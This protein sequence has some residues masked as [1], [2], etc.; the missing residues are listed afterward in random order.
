MDALWN[1]YASLVAVIVVIGTVFIFS[2]LRDIYRA[3]D[4]HRRREE[5]SRPPDN[6]E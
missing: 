4:F 5:A 6:P 1:S 3:Y 2:F